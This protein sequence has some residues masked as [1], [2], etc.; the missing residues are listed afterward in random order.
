MELSRWFR[1]PHTSPP[2]LNLLP[3][4]LRCLLC[5][6]A[7]RLGAPHLLAVFSLLWPLYSPTCSPLTLVWQ[8]NHT[9]LPKPSSA[10]SLSS[11]ALLS[12]TSSGL[13]CCSRLNGG[14][15]TSQ[16]TSTLLAPEIMYASSRASHTLSYG[17]ALGHMIS[18]PLTCSVSMNVHN[19]NLH[20]TRMIQ[21]TLSV[22]Y[23]LEEY[24]KFWSRLLQNTTYQSSILFTII[25]VQELYVLLI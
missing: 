19:G 11:H 18:V 2:Y 13:S 8:S 9:P 12:S 25:H 23:T 10:S 5:R 4:P 15:N 21:Y 22:N 17:T 16:C 7:S 3:S 6:S 20:P 14:Q 1:T 24:T